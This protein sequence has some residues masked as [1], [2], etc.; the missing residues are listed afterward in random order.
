[1]S[2][3]SREDMRYASGINRLT[4]DPKELMAEVM[5]LRSMLRQALDDLERVEGERDRLHG[6]LSRIAND[7]CGCSVRENDLVHTCR[8]LSDDEEKW[9]WCC[10]AAAA[11]EGGRR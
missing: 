2:S 1:M 5:E 7:G 9:C 3:Y 11:L 6:V 8:D 4:N 10:I